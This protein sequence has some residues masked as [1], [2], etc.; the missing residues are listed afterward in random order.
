MIGYA[1]PWFL[2]GLCL[3]VMWRIVRSH[4][5]PPVLQYEYT[6]KY[7]LPPAP[8]EPWRNGPY[9]DQVV[10]LP[11]HIIKSL[12][13]P[14]ELHKIGVCDEERMD[15]L[16]PLIKYDGVEQPFV[17]AFDALGR[18]T[19]A[20]GH[21]R[22]LLCEE[23]GEPE[24]PVRFEYADRIRKFSRPA[25]E[26]LLAIFQASRARADVRRSHKP[27]DAGAIPAAC[28]LGQAS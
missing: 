13:D 11:T 17:I 23:L 19:L 24:V 4:E 20:D 14:R 28:T 15:R 25:G 9:A 12:A 6:Y 16:R 7:D 10:L 21:H 8:K 1:I 5:Y 2:V 26:V 22:M 18:V 3:V 27:Q